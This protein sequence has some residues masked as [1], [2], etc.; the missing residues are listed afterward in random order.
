MRPTQT[1]WAPVSSL[2][3]AYRACL[4]QAQHHG[5]NFPTASRLFPKNHRLSV[6]AIYAFARTADD[7]ADE[8]GL[9]KDQRLEKLADWRH[10]LHAGPPR[11]G[12]PVFWALDHTRNRLSLPLDPLDRLISAFERDV[13]QSRHETFQDLLD[14]CSCS[15]NP[16]GELVLRVW[17]AWNPQRGAWS[18]SLCTGLQLVNFW[19]DITLDAKKDRIYIPRRITRDAGL[20]EDLIL[21]GPATEASSRLVLTLLS[22]TEPFF[23]QAR[24]LPGNVPHPLSLWLSAVWWGGYRVAQKI[25]RQSGDVWS[26]RPRLSRGDWVRL[27]PRILWGVR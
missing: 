14:Y 25:R 18:D 4:F 27:V 26:Q 6:A 24:P 16:V 21:N 23:E 2:E 11:D 15:A 20:Q 17:G 7:F 10:R 1:V 9:T 13:R 8:P 19:Q 3:E 12:H 5:E 22:Q